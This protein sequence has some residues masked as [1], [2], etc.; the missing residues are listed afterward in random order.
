MVN[1][2]ATFERLMEKMLMRLQWQTCLL[3]LDDIIIYSRGV[4]EHLRR[5]EN[6]LRK[7][8]AAGLKLKPAKYLLMKMLVTLEAHPRVPHACQAI[9]KAD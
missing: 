1:A 3:Y 6:F 5:I 9:A 2:P 7:F 8:E 4:T